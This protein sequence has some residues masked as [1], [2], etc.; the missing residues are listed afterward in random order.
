[1]HFRTATVATGDTVT[2]SI[3]TVDTASAGDPTGTLW[4]S[5]TNTTS[6]TVAVAG[7]D[8][9]VWKEC[10]LT[11]DATLAVGDVFA[12]VITNGGGG[13]NIQIQIAADNNFDFPYSDQFTATRT[14]VRTPTVIV[15]EYSDASFE[16]IFG[17]LDIG[18]PINT[19]TFDNNDAVTRRGNIFQ[20][21]FP[22][23]A[24]GCWVWIDA[25]N[26]FTVK[27]YDSDG[28]TVLAT[29]ATI[30][31]AQRMGNTGGLHF[32]PFT[33]TASL[34]ASTNYRVA[35][36]PSG[37][38]VVS[39]YDYDVPDAAMLDMFPGASEMHATAYDGAAWTETTT[40]RAY[41]GIYLDAFHNGAGT[42]GGR[43]IGGGN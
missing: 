39:T 8:D 35:V 24:K 13:G 18:A 7:G 30:D 3:E 1:V 9:N 17:Y 29:T 15:P 21:P 37:A 12:I 36:V 31:S 41:I 38:A 10:T 22:T 11:A 25:D 19:N 28:S 26:D 42:G 27:L 43:I 32:F 20:V 34:S 16:P 33:T 4:N 5:P 23:R 6:C 40:K 14:K 2:V